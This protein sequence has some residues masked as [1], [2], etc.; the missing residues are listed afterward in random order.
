MAGYIPARTVAQGQHHAKNRSSTLRKVRTAVCISSCYN[1]R[2]NPVSEC[3]RTLRWQDAQLLP[4]P[5][6]TRC[7]SGLHPARP[8]HHA[9]GQPQRTSPARTALPPPRSPP[10]KQTHSSGH[11]SE[12]GASTERTLT[13]SFISRLSSV[14][15]PAIKSGC[16]SK[17]SLSYSTRGT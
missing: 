9:L 16:L 8:C 17:W 14:S 3:I 11:Q 5:T 2:N 13:K 12:T 15:L 7:G 6:R 1:G 4:G 10:A